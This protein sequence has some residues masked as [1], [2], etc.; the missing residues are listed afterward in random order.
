MNNTSKTLVFFGT[1]D[2]SLTALT[3]LIEAGYTIAAVITK[4]DSK[5]G[6]GQKLVS[7][8]VKRIAEQ[9][10]IPVWQPQRLSEIAD[11]IRALDNP[12]GVL[13]SYGK[14]IPQSV[15]DLFTPGII[16]LHPSLLPTYRGPSPIESAIKHGDTLT[17]V[18]VMLLSKD[19]DAGPVYAAKNYSLDGTETKPEL[20]QALAVTGTDLLLEVLPAILDGS[21]QPSPQDDTQA[22]YSQLLQKSDA[23]LNLQQLSAINAERLVRAHLGFPK[24]KVVVEQHELIVTK[25][26]V[27]EQKNTP[28]DLLCQDGMFL[29][30][31]ELIAPSG[32]RMDSSAFLRGYIS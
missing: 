21:L 19:M 23:Y 29:S 4:P 16:N 1:E 5:K 15:I 8:Q 17:G 30:I 28:L 18:S 27:T 13:V 22:T 31:D 6:R 12:V 20:Y 2:F 7:P 24:T 14:I 32:R 9:H 3:G 10:N 26:H 25:A 11:D